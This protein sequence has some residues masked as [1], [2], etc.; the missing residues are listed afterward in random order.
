[1]LIFY[2]VCPGYQFDVILLDFIYQVKR[3]INNY[4]DLVFGYLAYPSIQFAFKEAYFVYMSFFI[5]LG[6]HLK[7]IMG[8][9]RVGPGLNK[10]AQVSLVFT[11]ELGGAWLLTSEPTRRLIYCRSI[12]T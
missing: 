1:M 4:F 5:W 10:T 7:E 11:T 9:G 6:F 8:T 12:A 3:V 2:I